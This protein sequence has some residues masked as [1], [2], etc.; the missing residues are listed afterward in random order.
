MSSSI[1]R[2]QRVLAE[3]F[4]QH[5]KA[6][7]HLEQR[8][9]LTRIVGRVLIGQTRHEAAQQ[10]DDVFRALDVAAEPEEVLGHA[11]GKLGG[12]GLEPDRIRWAQERHRADR[13]V[14]EHPRI[15]ALAAALH[16]D[17]RHVL[18]ARHAR[19]AAGHHRE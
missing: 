7:E 16:R 2:S 4:G 19:Q 9:H 3:L 17:D 8:R 10:P 14:G 18:R 13:T 15:L 6:D 11:A 5:S 12:G 1:L